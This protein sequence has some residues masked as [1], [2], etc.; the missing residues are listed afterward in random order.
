MTRAAVWIL[1]PR[2][3]QVGT[4]TIVPADAPSSPGVLRM[5]DSGAFGTGLHPTTALCVEAIENAIDVVQPDRLLDVGIGS[6]VL[7]LSAL[8]KG[9]PQATGL[10]I[11]ENVLRVAAE[12]AA[13]NGLED[14]LTLIHGGP[15]AVAGTWPL[16]VANVLAAPLID[17]APT[18]VRRIGHTGRLVLSGIPEAMDADVTRTYTRLGMR[19]VMSDAR[20]GW[21]VV[22]LDT[23]W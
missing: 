10:D 19:H 20:A 13:L 16:V 11:V 23:T 22:V 4:I 21:S 3:V 1:R 17:M 9:T 8:L 6:G 5:H 7:A 18:L 14:R 12:N 15:D 2:P